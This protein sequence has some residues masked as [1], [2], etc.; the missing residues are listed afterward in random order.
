MMPG[1][2]AANL[3]TVC[4]AAMERW[5]TENHYKRWPKGGPEAET[6]M[7]V[8]VEQEYWK[9]F[10]DKARLSE[11]MKLT[12]DWLARQDWTGRTVV[13]A[14]KKLNFPIPTSI[15]D[16]PFNYIIDRLDIMDDGETVEVVDYKSVMA[17][18]PP[19]EMHHR[20]QCRGYAAATWLLYP[21]AKRIWVT[22]DLLRHTPVSVAYTP[23]ECRETIEY[24][25]QLAERILADED[26]PETINDKC[27]WCARKW[28]CGEIK[29][30]VERTADPLLFGEIGDLAANR[31]KL[32]TAVSVM[33]TMLEDVDRILV[34]HLSTSGE[35]TAQEKDSTG[36]VWSLGMASRRMRKP[37]TL[38]ALAKVIGPGP[39]IEIA[40]S[41]SLK[42][43]EGVIND[44]AYTEEQRQDVRRLIGTYSTSP[45]MTVKKVE[46]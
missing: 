17:P 16:I 35:V 34:E 27:R 38:K 29:N 21:D 10:S 22:F 19:S 20:I 46:S 33:T 6:K 26:A 12:L 9:L 40:G 45:S 7:A 14:E 41:P 18:V 24:L 43:V 44:P 30:Y 13:S 32:K 1:G 11:A 25:R 4:H 42:A 39:A 31:A 28:D 2:S 36:A 5:V 23:E 3:G 8:I 15:G 37:P